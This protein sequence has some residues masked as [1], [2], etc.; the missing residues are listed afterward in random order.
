MH[1]ILEDFTGP[2]LI[3]TN[4]FKRL[5]TRSHLRCPSKS[6][7]FYNFCFMKIF[8]KSTGLASL[9]IQRKVMKY[10]K[11]IF[12]NKFSDLNFAKIEIQQGWLNIN[13]FKSMTPHHISE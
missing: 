9:A 1:F 13:E 11:K 10:L 3:P 5:V 12:A 2:Q 6:R 8:Q 4:V 7:V